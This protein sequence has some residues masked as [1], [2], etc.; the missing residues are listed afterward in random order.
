MLRA[1]ADP[2]YPDYA[3]ITE[4]LDGYDPNK[5]EIFPIEVALDKIAGC[6]NTASDASLSTI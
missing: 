4:W 6:R 2:T 3:E 1:T 5:M